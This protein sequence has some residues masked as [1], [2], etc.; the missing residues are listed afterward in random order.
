MLLDN[1]HTYEMLLMGFQLRIIA[2]D[3]LYRTNRATADVIVNV[4][5]AN[6]CPQFRPSATYSTSISQDVN[7]G[8]RLIT[9]G[10]FDAENVRYDV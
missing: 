3:H 9:I 7:I 4:N 10:A 8:H 6:T 1:K 2:Y 5:C